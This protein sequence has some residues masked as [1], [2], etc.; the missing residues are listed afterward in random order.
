MDY[1]V[2]HIKKWKMN[3]KTRLNNF[4]TWTMELL[5]KQPNIFDNIW[6][7]YTDSSY[8]YV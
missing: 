8:K 2:S 5:S 6:E 4:S 7:V 1:F 3:E